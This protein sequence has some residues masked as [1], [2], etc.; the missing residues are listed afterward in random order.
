MENCH[1][2]YMMKLAS[3][4]EVYRLMTEGNFLYC[5]RADTI[6]KENCSANS[7]THKFCNVAMISK[8]KLLL[9]LLSRFSRVRPHRR[10][11]TRLCCLWDSP[12]KNTGVGCHCLLC[13]LLTKYLLIVHQPCQTLCRKLSIISPPKN[14]QSSVEARPENRRLY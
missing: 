9:L 4:L 12:G 5:H 14:L 1:T 11:P 2:D 13:H 10:Q 7:T 8:L 6:I 3:V